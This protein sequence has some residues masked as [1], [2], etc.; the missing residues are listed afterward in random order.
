[1]IL[2]FFAPGQADQHVDVV[3]H[4]GGF[5]RHGRHQLELFQLAFGFLARLDGHAGGLDL[6]LDLF[7]VGAL[8][9]FAQLFLNGLDLLVQVEVALVLFHLALDAAADALV[10]IEDV[11]FALELRVQVFQAGFDFRQVEHQLLVFQLQGQVGGNGVGQ[12]ARVVDAGDRGEDFG[13]NFFVQFDVLVELLHDR[14]A[15]GLDF[16]VLCG[17]VG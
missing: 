2:V 3:A 15:Q 8:F 11:H 10:D 17:V 7:N 1:L 14:A 6:F 16:G 13:R 12:A 5:G 9:A 4:H